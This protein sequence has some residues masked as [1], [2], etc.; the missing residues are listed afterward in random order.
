MIINIRRWDA[1][2]LGNAVYS[3]SLGNG[4]L[5]AQRLPAQ[6]IIA[7]YMQLFTAEHRYHNSCGKYLIADNELIVLNILLVQKQQV[8]AAGYY[9]VYFPKDTG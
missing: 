1:V 5:L 4:Q 2:K 7:L 6:S 9:F 8:L 3:I